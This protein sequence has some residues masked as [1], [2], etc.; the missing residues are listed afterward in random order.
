MSLLSLADYENIL[1]NYGSPIYVY[2]EDQIRA[3]AKQF[4]ETFKHY[5]PN[6]KQFFAV[7]ATPNHHI[8]RILQEYN[9]GF[10][11]SSLTELRLTDEMFWP[12]DIMYTSNYTS[13]EDFESILQK[14]DTLPYPDIKINLDDIDGLVNLCQASKNTKIPLPQT[15]GFRL[16]PMYGE[17]SSGIISNVFGG[18]ETKFGIPSNKIVDAYVAAKNKGFTKFGIHIMTGSCILDINY[19]KNLI[20]TVYQHIDMIYKETGICIQYI[21][22]GGGIG[23]PYLPDEHPIDINLLAKTIADQIAINKEK[24]NIM[25]D[26]VICME[27]GRYITG[28]YGVLVS[29]CK[30]IKIGYNDKKFYGLDA[31]MSNLMRPGMYGAYHKITLPRLSDT[32]DSEIKE[33]ESVNVVGMLC[34]NNDWFAKNRELPRGIMKNDIFVIHDAGAHGHSM[35]FQYNGRLRSA[36]VLVSKINKTTKLI[37]DKEIIPDT[38]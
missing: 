11:C 9:M 32:K 10:D 7:K 19:F 1:T 20:D 2:D 22:L 29:R 12:A 16:N 25:Y 23:I 30:S 36:E 21:D 27:N 34:E 37:R 26:S 8:M 35:G 15:I 28:P 13:V 38:F 14:I 6:F 31:C 3:N 33:T 5:I 18:P 4:M 17:T 24:Y